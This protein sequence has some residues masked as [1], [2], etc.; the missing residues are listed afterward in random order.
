MQPPR[1]PNVGKSKVVAR[2]G[3]LI[4]VNSKNFNADNSGKFVLLSPCFCR[5][6]YQVHVIK[7]FAIKLLY[8]S[9]QPFLGCHLDFYIFFLAF[10]RAAHFF[11]AG[12][13]WIRF[14]YYMLQSW[15]I[16]INGCCY[17]SF[18]V[19]FYA[20]RCMQCSTCVSCILFIL[21]FVHV[22]DCR[23]IKSKREHVTH[24]STK[25]LLL[26]TIY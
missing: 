23:L 2:N 10:L 22:N 3:R 26:S 14:H 19:F 24:T 21:I 5:I 6:Q 1:R 18:T 11:T 17:L 7:I 4:V 15:Y 13:F 16:V 9:S 12:C 8:V 20:D 25:T